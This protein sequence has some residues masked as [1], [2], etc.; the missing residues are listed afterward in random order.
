MLL[1]R[2]GRRGER[3]EERGRRKV[4][5][6]SRPCQSPLAGCSE[7]AALFPTAWSGDPSSLALLLRVGAVRPSN[8]SLPAFPHHQ[9]HPP[10]PCTR[11]HT[12]LTFP[13]TQPRLPR[14]PTVRVLGTVGV[15]RV[16]PP[17]LGFCRLV[18]VLDPMKEA[19]S[20]CQRWTAPWR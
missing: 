19:H 17:L 5:H 20:A 4:S 12:A 16:R 7:K 8:A 9:T 6:G 14:V 11:M 1:L 15:P 13:S 3:G 10:H 18:F 2:G